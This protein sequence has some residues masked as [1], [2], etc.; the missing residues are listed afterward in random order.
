MCGISCACL[1]GLTLGGFVA[2]IVAAL[3]FAGVL[4]EITIGLLI[5]LSISVVAILL[6]I[7]SLSSCCR[8]NLDCF[9]ANG[10]C[11][12]FGAIGTII[13]A[14]IALSIT[15]TPGE[16]LGTIII[17][18]VAFFFTVTISSIISLIICLLNNDNNNDDDDD[19]DEDN[20]SCNCSNNNSNNNRNRSNRRCCRCNRN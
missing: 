17:A 6:L 3:F 19:D 2:L 13:F 10:I 11:L 15:L 9:R 12:L 20:D 7:V 8:R 4:T 14:I 5:V 18:L 16:I 1:I